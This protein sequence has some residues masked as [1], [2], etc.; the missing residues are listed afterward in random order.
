MALDTELI[1]MIVCPE[2]REKL[3]LADSAVLEK[4]NAA[5]Q[6]G[7]LRTRGGRAVSA[8]IAVALVR[9]DGKV[10]FVVEDDIPNLVPDEAIPLEGV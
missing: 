10:A 3:A 9:P 5:A 6:G 2:T 7:T 8:P 4:L 1:E